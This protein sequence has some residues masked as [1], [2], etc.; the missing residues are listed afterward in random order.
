[1]YSYVHFVVDLCATISCIYV[2]INKCNSLSQTIFIINPTD[3]ILQ[4]Q[5]LANNRQL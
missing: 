4:P 5:S 2:N 1:M 3:P